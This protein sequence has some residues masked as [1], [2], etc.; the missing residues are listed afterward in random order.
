[1]FLKG[2]QGC[3][4]WGLFGKGFKHIAFKYGKYHEDN[5]RVVGRLFEFGRI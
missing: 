4:N 1:M 2:F 3:E 5:L